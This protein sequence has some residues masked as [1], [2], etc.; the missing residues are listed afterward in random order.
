MLIYYVCVTVGIWNHITFKQTG[1]QET[2]T[3]ARKCYLVSHGPI[4]S[5]FNP[6]TKL[7]DLLKIFSK[8]MNKKGQA[9]RYLR[10]KFSW[11]NDAKIKKVIFNELQIQ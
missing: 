2:L 8:V 7:L 11:L 3:L 6:H 1:P 10:D 9:I 5:S 4:R